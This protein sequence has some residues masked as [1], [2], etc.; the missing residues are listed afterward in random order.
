MRGNKIKGNEKERRSNLKRYSG[1]EK[2]GKCAEETGNTWGAGV[3]E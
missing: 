3:A 2:T 1:N